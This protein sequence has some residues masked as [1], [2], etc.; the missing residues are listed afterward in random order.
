MQTI[1]TLALTWLSASISITTFEQATACFRCQCFLTAQFCFSG[2]HT[3]AVLGFRQ[4]LGMDECG[5]TAQ[6]RT[7]EM[8]RS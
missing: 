2:T 7:R 6:R 5:A 1:R 4:I 3:E 8:S